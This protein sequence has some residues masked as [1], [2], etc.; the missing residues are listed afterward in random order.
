M[1]PH[2][3]WML[4]V[5]ALAACGSAPGGTDEPKPSPP[6]EAATDG[7]PDALSLGDWASYAAPEGEEWPVTG[8]D[9]LRWAI[10]TAELACVDRARQGDPEAQGDGSRRV[11][12]HHRT[13]A[14][15]VM[16]YGIAVNGDATRATRLGE[17]VAVAAENCS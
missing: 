8:L 15:A 10:V 6:R 14:A 11:L 7:L 5:F 2:R 17:L 12:A 13:S 3:L 9:D 4:L 16:D 1:P